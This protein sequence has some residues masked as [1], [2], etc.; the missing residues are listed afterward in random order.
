MKDASVS[1]PLKGLPK[2]KALRK[3]FHGHPWP[4]GHEVSTPPPNGSDKQ[5]STSKGAKSEPVQ[6]LSLRS[7]P[8]E[9]DLATPPVK[10][11]TPAGSSG[12]ELKGLPKKKALHDH[13]KS[14]VEKRLYGDAIVPE[15][16]SEEKGAV[17]FVGFRMLDT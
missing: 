4:R 10:S 9:N 14:P 8:S 11:P 15:L 16:D 12:N 3:D 7:L 1:S 6:V 13:R 5:N 17:Q 2:Q